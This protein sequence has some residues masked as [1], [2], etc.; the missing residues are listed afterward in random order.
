MA[1]HL[2]SLEFTGINLSP[3]EVKVLS[4]GLQSNTVLTSFS[5][6]RVNLTDAGADYLLPALASTQISLLALSHVGLTDKSRAN[7]AHLVKTHCWKRDELT[8]AISLRC[9]KGVCPSAK[10]APGEIPTSGILTLDLSSNQLGDDTASA[11]SHALV[12]D[13]WLLGIDLSRNRIGMKGATALCELL[14]QNAYVA[15]VKMD[16]NP[17]FLKPKGREGMGMMQQILAARET[18]LGAPFP[19]PRPT[20]LPPSSLPASLSSILSALSIASTFPSPSARASSQTA[21]KI[22][23]T[24]DS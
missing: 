23:V 7:I 10:T 5:L 19:A 22:A 6:K 1:P 18:A 16:S 8:W 9:K 20:H 2:C 12:H 11:L 14:V 3:L 15:A 4:S 24:P 21:L 17:C 13:G